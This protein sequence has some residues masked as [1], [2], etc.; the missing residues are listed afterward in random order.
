[1]TK[2]ILTDCARSDIVLLLPASCFLVSNCP[3]L[4]AQIHGVTVVFIL[5]ETLIPS[6]NLLTD[7]LRV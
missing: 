5:V 6:E 4:S 1:M 2:I 3:Q 7:V